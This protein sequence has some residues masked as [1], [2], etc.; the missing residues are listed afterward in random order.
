MRPT[1]PFCERTSGA[2]S[3]NVDAAGNSMRLFP[4][5]F[6]HL[7]RRQQ[8][9]KWHFPRVP[10]VKP[11]SAVPNFIWRASNLICE[12]LAELPTNNNNTA[13]MD[14]QRRANIFAANPYITA[15]VRVSELGCVSPAALSP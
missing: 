12:C 6:Y 8:R 13:M 2:L 10:R 3:Q 4:S 11:F 7:A 1:F 9:Q 15:R 14:I 5:S